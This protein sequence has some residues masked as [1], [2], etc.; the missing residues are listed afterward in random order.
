MDLDLKQ[1]HLV[2]AFPVFGMDSLPFK[3]NTF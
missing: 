2:W 1:L 3:Q